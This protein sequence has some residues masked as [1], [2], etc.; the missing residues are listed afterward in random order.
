MK[1]LAPFGQ[2]NPEPVWV[3]LGIEVLDKPRVVGQKHLKLTMGSKGRQ[4][5]AIAFNYSLEQ[6]PAGMLDIAFTLKEN[7]WNGNTSLQLQIKDIRSA[8]PA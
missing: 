7:S 2:D 4:F 5:D 8:E 3:L 1:R 6:L